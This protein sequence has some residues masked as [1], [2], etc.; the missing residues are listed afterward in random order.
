MKDTLPKTYNQKILRAIREF[1]LITPGDRIL[2]GF[3]G[4]KDSAFLIYS[5]ALLVKHRIIKAELAALTIDLGFGQGIDPAP[6]EEFCSGLDLKFYF[7]RTKIAQWVQKERTPCA[8]CSYLRRASL[9]RFASEHGFNKLALAHHHDD[10]VE[11]FLMSI[12]Y[13]GQ[14]RTFLPRTD[15]DRSGITVIRP[16]VYLREKEITD[17]KEFVRFNPVRPNCPYDGSTYRQKVKELIAE[18]TRENPWVYPNLA[19]AMREGG[20]LELWPPEIKL[21]KRR[22]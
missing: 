9:S 15:L 7:Y 18:L 10:A 8:R 2:I 22:M 19:T 17:A 12:I 1:E 13:S 6:F 20:P 14:I 21:G 4:G 5:L 16:L 11:T 3:S